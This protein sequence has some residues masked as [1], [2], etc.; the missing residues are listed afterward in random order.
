MFTR[1]VCCVSHG[2]GAR[3]EHGGGRSPRVSPGLP[4]I[5]GSSGSTDYAPHP[6]HAARSRFNSRRRRPSLR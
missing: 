3:R 5:E 6:D 1:L 2:P 4:L